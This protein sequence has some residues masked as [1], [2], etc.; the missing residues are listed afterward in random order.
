VHPG[1]FAASSDDSRSSK[2]GKV[3][4]DS[5]LGEPKGFKDF[6]DALLT[7]SQSAKNLQSDG[8]TEE[9]KELGEVLHSL[10]AICGYTN[11]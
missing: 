6:T 7:R 10:I 4:R 3:A 1:S 9:R 2:Q 5:A 8:F 11:I